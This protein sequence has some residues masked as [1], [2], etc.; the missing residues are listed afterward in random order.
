MFQWALNWGPILSFHEQRLC[1][2]DMT[3]ALNVL[4]NTGPV[5]KVVGVGH[6][7]R[8]EGKGRFLSTFE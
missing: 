1:L 3:F 6:L 5:T 4:L 2:L 7:S 8:R